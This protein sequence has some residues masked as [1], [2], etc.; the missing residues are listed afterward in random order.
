VINKTPVSY[1]AT[2]LNSQGLKQHLFLFYV[3]V[4]LCILKPLILDYEIFAVA[5]T[6]TTY[7]HHEDTL[8][9]PKIFSVKLKQHNLL[10]TSYCSCRYVLLFWLCFYLCRRLWQGAVHGPQEGPQKWSVC[11]GDRCSTMLATYSDF[12][13]V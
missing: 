3:F 6:S 11:S 9:K 10:Y 4:V 8:Q 2:D 5:G 7:N 13:C 12:I 1:N